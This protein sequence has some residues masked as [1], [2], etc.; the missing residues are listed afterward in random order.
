MVGGFRVEREDP[1]GVRQERVDRCPRR[2]EAA[3]RC[4]SDPLGLS[5]VQEVQQMHGLTVTS[6]INLDD[7]VA[8]LHQHPE[9]SQYLQAVQRYRE[10]YGVSY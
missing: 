3:H 10:R 6:I 1:C 4:R 5:A 2:G 8:Y 7:L 9:L